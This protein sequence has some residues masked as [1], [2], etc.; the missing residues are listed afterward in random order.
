M[1]E[2]AGRG[3]VSAALDRVAQET[4]KRGFA[5]ELQ[6]ACVTKGIALGLNYLHP[7]G[8]IHR[9][10]KPENILLNWYEEFAYRFVCV[11]RSATFSTISLLPCV[12]NVVL[13]REGEIKLADFGISRIVSE[14]Q[15]AATLVGTPQYLAPEVVV[16][17]EKGYN[18]KVDVWG[19]GMVLLEMADGL[20]LF[21]DLTPLKALFR[22]ADPDLHVTVKDESAWSPLLISFLDK[23]MQTNP[24]QRMDVAMALTHPFIS[25]DAVKPMLVD[26]AVEVLSES[27]DGQDDDLAE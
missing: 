21:A 7:R 12:L 8:I 4:G 25:E 16:A 1:L 26:D 9:D 10:I 19:M 14:H 23:C 22:L 20:P 24:A 2:L 18:A 3:S 15:K 11:C 5:D 13:H 17:G 27:D 6:I